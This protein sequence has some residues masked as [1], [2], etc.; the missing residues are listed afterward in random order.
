MKQLTDITHLVIDMD[1]VLYVG[2]RPM[3]CLPEF[4]AF[5]RR[6]GIGFMLATN[7]SG[8]TPEQ[9]AAKL[10][11][12]GAV[13]APEEIITSGTATAEWLDRLSSISRVP[14]RWPATL[15]T[16]SVRP[17]MNQ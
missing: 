13:V 6:N 2:D 3:P 12:M 14:S 8:S 1:G 4:I 15:I 10:A 16:S 5:L 7:N 9:Y 17:R 11:R